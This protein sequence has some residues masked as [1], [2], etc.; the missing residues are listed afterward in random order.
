MD[1][2]TAGIIDWIVVIA[3]SLKLKLFR[4]I[5]PNFALIDS[6]LL[7]W[8]LQFKANFKT[9]LFA[10]YYLDGALSSKLPFRDCSTASIWFRSILRF[11]CGSVRLPISTSRPL[12]AYLAIGGSPLTFI[13]KHLTLSG[14]SILSGNFGVWNSEFAKIQQFP[15]EFHS[16]DSSPRIVAHFSL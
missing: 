13:S 14:F 10:K 3:I 4:L 12:S 16:S 11:L 7:N 15:S 1:S 6:L 2:T 9:S 8:I 5:S